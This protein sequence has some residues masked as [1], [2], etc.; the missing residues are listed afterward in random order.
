VD[1]TRGT[2]GLA[3]TADPTSMADPITRSITA[4][5]FLIRPATYSRRQTAVTIV[6]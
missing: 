4:D 5:A 6:T 3:I 1:F 2:D